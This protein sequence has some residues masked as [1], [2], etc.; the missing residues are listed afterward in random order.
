MIKYC[1][2]IDSFAKVKN[3][4]LN[5]ES[6]SKKEQKK[7][8][9]KGFYPSQ[10]LIFTDKGKQ[11]DSFSL[12]E[13]DS[14]LTRFPSEEA[15]L[16]YLKKA[17]FNYEFSG[18]KHLI[19]T[20]KYANI[21]KQADL[22][23]DSQLL[24]YYSILERQKTAQ[25]KKAKAPLTESNQK[26]KEELEK[27]YR[28]L[29][30]LARDNEKRM[31]ITWPP[32]F[33]ETLSHTEKRHLHKYLKK[34]NTY[35]NKNEYYTVHTLHDAL[36][37]YIHIHDIRLKNIRLNQSTLNDDIELLEAEKDVYQTLRKDYATLRNAVLFMQ[38]VAKIEASKAFYQSDF[39]T[40]MTYIADE[41]NLLQLHDN[42]SRQ[43][44]IEYLKELKENAEELRKTAEECASTNR[45][46][47]KRETIEDIEE[48][49]Y[50]ISKIEEELGEYTRY[51]EEI[52]EQEQNNGKF[53]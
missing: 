22:I 43:A 3:Q 7:L 46:K 51:D 1:L 18:Q 50:G 27:F 8:I 31:Y 37:N 29:L 42:D 28:K 5:F 44:Y 16:N 53:K 40:Q 36:E 4:I 6:L 52:E 48:I 12:L 26:A 21:V 33:M 9:E 35:R 47:T 13:I 15:F 41:N 32:N 23:F 45:K 11:K 10:R 39:D 24:F 19:C 38:T 17:H 14:L 20:Y 34:G 2:W 30:A 25:D 49:D